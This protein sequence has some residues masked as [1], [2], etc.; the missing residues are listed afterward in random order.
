MSNTRQILKLKFDKDIDEVNDII[1]SYLQSMKFIEI[2]YNGEKVYKHNSFMTKLDFHKT[3]LKIH[4]TNNK[5]T[6]IG[7]IVSKNTEY[8]FDDILDINNVGKESNWNLTKNLYN[9]FYAFGSGL[10][11]PNNEILCKK[12]SSNE[13]VLPAEQ[14]L[15]VYNR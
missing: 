12:V 7:W 10:N 5:L 2:D 14:N 15:F 9:M 1:N 13:A 8:G 6:L 4:L 11:S 3:Y